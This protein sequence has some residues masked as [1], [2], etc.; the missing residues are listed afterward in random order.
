MAICRWRW[1]L[2]GAVLGDGNRAIG[3]VSG[4]GSDN[5]G[6]GADAAID[7]HDHAGFVK[8]TPGNVAGLERQGV[9]SSRGETISSR[10]GRSVGAAGS[11]IDHNAG[12]HVQGPQT[13]PTVRQ[14][15]PFRCPGHSC[16]ARLSSAEETEEGPADGLTIDQAIEMLVHRNLDLKAKQLEIPKARRRADGQSAG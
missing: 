12:R 14:P 15:S 9:W 7:D 4:P 13:K 1:I 2:G 6:D 5:R 8:F 10:P 3:D 11:D 16:T